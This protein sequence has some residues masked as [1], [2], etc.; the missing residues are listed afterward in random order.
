MNNQI[1][2]VKEEYF[3][4]CLSLLQK[5]PIEEVNEKHLATRAYFLKEQ[6]NLAIVEYE[7]NFYN[8]IFDT[9]REEINKLKMA[10]ENKSND[11]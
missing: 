9:M 10:I 11:T 6:L 5:I 2:K 3:E 8:H 1:R 7:Q 4:F